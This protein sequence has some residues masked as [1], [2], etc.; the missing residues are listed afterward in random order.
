MMGAAAAEVLCTM[1]GDTFKLDD[2][3]HAMVPEFGIKPRCFN[4]FRD[5]A[6]ENA[7]SR[8]LIGVHWRMDAEEGLR[9]GA[10]IGKEVNQMQVEKKLTE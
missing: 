5:M 9:L 2:K 3:S 6:R 4:S 10:L 8:I 7:L 1:Y